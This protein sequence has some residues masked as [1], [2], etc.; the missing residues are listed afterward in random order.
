[1]TNSSDGLRPVLDHVVIN[2]LGNLDAAAAQYERLGFRLTE[3]G[4]HTL[5]SS[6][7]LAIFGTDYL[8]LLGYLPGREAMR[9]DLWRHPAG[10]TG[11]VFKA[12]DPDFVHGT[13]R[14]RG[15]PVQA[16]V[17]FARP[18]AL[19]EGT[20]DARFA[21]VRVSS[22][23]VQNGRTYFCQHMT[24]ELVWRSQWQTHENGVIGIAEF[25]IASRDPARAGLL[26]E[27][28]FGPHLLCPVPGGVSFRAGG[29][30]VLLLLPQ[31]IRERY[32]GAALVSADGTD[33][34]VA[35]TFKTTSIEAA[36]A[37]LDRGGVIYRLLPAG[38]IVVPHDHAANVALA[39]IS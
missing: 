30:S 1:M 9:P 7:N 10:L 33:R 11:L 34:M 13:L 4:H 21:V 28:M 6:N 26:Y 35:L 17:R 39:F 32:A 5:G 16:P 2:V 19:P 8:E 36:R 12:D 25:V 20:R 18:V 22:D 27:Q 38:G 23:V 14:D 15:L 31:A 37:V 24:P 29:T 3:R